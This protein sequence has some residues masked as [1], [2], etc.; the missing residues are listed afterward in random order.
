MEK[1]YVLVR[2]DL[3]GSSSAVQA[4]HAVAQWM[5]DYPETWKNQTLVYI[6]IGTEDELLRWKQK[7]HYKDMNYSEFKEPDLNDETTAIA[8]LTDRNVFNGLSLL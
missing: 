1:L 3:Q 6:N 8:C 4:G 5:L 7:I 2:T